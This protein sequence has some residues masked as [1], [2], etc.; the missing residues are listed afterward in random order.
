MSNESNGPEVAPPSPRGWRRAWR[1]VEPWVLLST[2]LAGAVLLGYPLWYIGRPVTA[3]DTVYRIAP[4]ESLSGFARVLERDGLLPERYSFLLWAR[5]RG[6]AR[7]I[8][9]GDYRFDD[10]DTI[11]A[12]LEKMARGDVVSYRVTLVEGWT[13]ADALAR[14]AATPTLVRTLEGLSSAQIMAQLGQADEHPEGRF[15]PDTYVHTSAQTDLSILRSA[16]ERMTAVLE[17]EWA[18]RDPATPLSTPY[19]ALILA[20][21]IEKETAVAA[22]RGRIAGVFVNRLRRG[23]RLQTDPTVI[24]GI[25]AAFDGNLTR[26][27]LRADTPYNTYTRAGLPPTPIAIPGRASLRAALQPEATSALYFVARGDG[28]HVFSDT[29][30]A[31]NR[32]V[33]RYQLSGGGA[34]AQQG[35]AAD[36]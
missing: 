30:E 14:L 12:L 32:A 24:Y 15:F 2:V 35:G 26:T 9:A 11:G 28:T 19:Q 36:D 5:V 3:D 10:V 29:L 16:Y 17:Q 34:V 7:R 21:I 6:Y 20:S 1:R 27:H 31:H 22:E 13:F 4:G 18:E 33:R 8:Q 25:G 23:M